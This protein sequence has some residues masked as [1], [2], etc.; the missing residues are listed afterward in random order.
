MIFRTEPCTPWH[1]C[2]MH[3]IQSSCSLWWDWSNNL[4]LVCLLRVTHTIH[5]PCFHPHKRWWR[6]TNNFP[7]APLSL[8]YIE[9]WKSNEINPQTP[10]KQSLMPLM[11]SVRAGTNAKGGVTVTAAIAVVHPSKAQQNVTFMWIHIVERICS[12]ASISPLY[13]LLNLQYVEVDKSSLSHPQL[14]H[15]SSRKASHRHIPCISVT[16]PAMTQSTFFLYSFIV[17]SYC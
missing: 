10:R 17:Y 6:G 3:Y 1:Y 5:W 8:L 14:V 7:W 13:V 16:S 2:V 9:G 12:H 11:R 4:D 15:I